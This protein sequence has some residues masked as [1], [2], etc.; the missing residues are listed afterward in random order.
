MINYREADSLVV[1]REQIQKL[2]PFRDTRSDGWIGDAAH[3]LRKSDHN[4]WVMNGKTGIVTAQDIDSDL[5][6]KNITMDSIVAAICRSKDNRVKYLIWNKQITAK[7]SQLQQWIPYTGPDPHKSHL[8]ISVLPDVRFY[9][10]TR[11]WILQ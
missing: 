7:N 10:N 1:L 4:P 9:D 2:C 11:L 5:N 8:H 3:Q 6:S